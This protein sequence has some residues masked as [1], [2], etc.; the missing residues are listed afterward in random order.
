MN[1]DTLLNGPDDKD[2]SSGVGEHLDELRR[3][4]IYAISLPLLLMATAWTLWWDYIAPFFDGHF[5]ND[6][7]RKMVTRMSVL[8]SISVAFSASTQ[9]AIFMSIPW[10]IWHIWRFVSPGL[11][12]HE[13]R[14]ARVAMPGAIG[15]FCAGAVF[16][17]YVVIPFSLDFLLSF[18]TDEIGQ[19]FLSVDTF[20][21]FVF[22][23][24]LI[25]GLTFQIPVVVAPLVRFGVVQVDWFRRYRR[26]IMFLSAVLGAVL[27]P[28]VDPVT[29]MLVATPIYFLA[30]GGVWLGR[31]WKRWAER[32]AAREP[33]SVADGWREGLGKSDG[34]LGE[35]AA[36]S[37]ADAVGKFAR[38]F[39]SGVSEGGKELSKLAGLESEED[40]Q[41]PAD[42]SDQA[43]AALAEPER[44]PD[45]S[46]DDQTAESPSDPSDAPAS[47]EVAADAMLESRPATDSAE[48]DGEPAEQPRPDP[49]HQPPEASP[50]ES[51]R[52]SPE[53]EHSNQPQRGH[54]DLAPGSPAQ[55][56]PM[57]PMPARTVTNRELADRIAPKLPRELR[58]RIDAYVRQ[59]MRELLDEVLSEMGFAQ[60][61]APKDKNQAEES[62]APDTTEQR[63]KQ[64][65]QDNASS[66]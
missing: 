25:T 26:V 21:P 7:Q 10:V 14:F 3:S 30:E 15:L 12:D 45:Q 58:S 59:R 60:P 29:M 37:F 55:P 57:A 39:S 47:T 32:R 44:L 46:Q 20:Y 62:P 4:V 63:D 41:K 8:D 6:E 43:S 17:F 49:A 42:D 23:L 50:E 51:P 38:E 54:I 34:L 2:D 31:V 66:E 33:Q 48:S 40:Q 56:H 27:T 19:Q 1:P 22:S 65:E 28:T 16:A 35:D 13:K 64:D 53:E 18:G 5:L 9:L 61:E 36:Q 24:L 11:Y 52:E